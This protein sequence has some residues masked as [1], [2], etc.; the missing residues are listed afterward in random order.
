MTLEFKGVFPAPP[1]PVTDDGQVTTAR[2]TPDE[3]LRIGT[4]YTAQV[5][6]GLCEMVAGEPL[7]VDDGAEPIAVHRLR[8]T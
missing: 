6:D 2:L 8:N 1:T 3:P 7:A 5:F 4:V